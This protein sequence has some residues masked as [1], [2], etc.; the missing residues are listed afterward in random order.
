MLDYADD[1]VL[2]GIDVQHASQR[3]DIRTLT[4]LHLPM[5]EIHAA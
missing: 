2:V 4:V 5:A 1:G 3:A